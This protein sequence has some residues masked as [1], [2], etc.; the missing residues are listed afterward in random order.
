MVLPRS[1]GGTIVL[2]RKAFR[3]R[4]L[5]VPTGCYLITTTS[6]HHRT[7]PLYFQHG[8]LHISCC[9]N[10]E[11]FEFDMQRIL[12]HRPRELVRRRDRSLR[13]LSEKWIILATTPDCGILED[14]LSHEYWLV[15]KL[16]IVHTRSQTAKDPPPASED[17][18]TLASSVEIDDELGM[19]VVSDSSGS[20]FGTFLARPSGDGTVSP[21]WALGGRSGRGNFMP[22]RRVT[23]TSSAKR[24]RSGAS[25]LVVVQPTEKVL[26]L[27]LCVICRH[28]CT[29]PSLRDRV[30]VNCKSPTRL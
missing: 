19:P 14:C 16:S 20:S 2:S 27:V 25:Q 8:T 4:S 26:L 9:H 23:G 17:D 15:L 30:P 6:A 11:L 3:S 12:T 7:W 21:S 18:Q 28:S 22:G 10:C 5:L 13:S 29:C 24:S 1:R